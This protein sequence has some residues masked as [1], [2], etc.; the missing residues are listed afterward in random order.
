MKK[1]IIAAACILFLFTGSA[2]AVGGDPIK[3]KAKS[4]ACAACHG[5]DG[6]SPTPIWPSLAG[7]HTRYLEKQLADFLS[8]K[9]KNDQMSAMALVLSPDDIPDVA[10]YYASQRIKPGVAKEEMVETGEMLYRAG[11]KKTSLAACMGCHGPAGKGNL[12]AGYPSLHGQQATYTAA[13]LKAF[14]SV[15][16]NNDVNASMRIIAA[17]MTDEQIEAVSEYIQGLY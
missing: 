2:F 4:A 8:G 5:P 13:Q 16:R 12:A 14:K 10:A 11:D 9:R 7:Q 1:P 3:G 17:R 6:N 15:T